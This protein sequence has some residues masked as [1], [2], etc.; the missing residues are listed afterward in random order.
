MQTPTVAETEVCIIGAG[1]AGLLVATEL[2]KQQIHVVILE[3][4]QRHP[5]AERPDYAK[6]FLRGENPWQSAVPGIDAH[7]TAGRVRYSLDWMRAR[8]VGGSSLHWEGY[9]LR[10]HP[11]DF[12][13]R[14]VHGIADD[15]PLTYEKLEP[16]YASA[17]R[18]LGVAGVAD[19]PWA[20][21]RSSAFP[22]P[23]FPF[24][25][26][27]ALFL[28]AC[29]RL[30]IAL[31]HL[32]QA[33]NSIAYAGR[34]QCRACGTCHVCPTGAKASVDLTHAPQLEASPT[35]QILAET[36]ALRLQVDPSG[37]VGSV[38]YVGP[39]RAQHEL[40]S[41]IFVL[42]AGGV[43]TPRLLLLS[44]SPS[45][46][47]GLANRSGCV[48]R[49]FMSHPSLDVSGR[50]DAKTYPYRIGFSTAMCRQFAVE[51]DRR[52]HGAFMLEILNRAGP[53]PQEI[54]VASGA[55]GRALRQAVAEQFG[56]WVGIRIYCEQL[57]D[58]QNAVTLDPTITDPFGQPV[59]HLTYDVGPYERQ[60]LRRALDIATSIL[61]AMG[62]AEI[63]VAHLWHGAHQIGT[64]RMG[65]DP[66]SS[67]VDADLRCHDVENLYLVG[68]G[69]FVT[70][71]ASPPTL[72]IAA[73]ATRA[74][75]HIASILRHRDQ[76]GSADAREDMCKSF[77]N[78]CDSG[79]PEAKF[80]EA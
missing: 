20:A 48:G 27:D 71:S 76:R 63:R 29:S 67:V 52:R 5:L 33:R 19:D 50:L 10:L 58:G 3:S 34:S 11:D 14:R 59:P 45:H 17:E 64:C 24:S 18:A 9:T 78:R 77:A 37:R 8:G 40:K 75:E 47:H 62:A 73:L 46:P 42:A 44:S 32:P 49:Y 16:Y 72:T 53:A 23:P 15:W 80:E 35:V 31:Q 60:T 39:D 30:G 69:V 1:P 61:R 41:R 26:S 36:T 54:A 56:H 65:V 43:E 4:G 70:G 74:G 25:Y 6:R 7:T 12:Q 66:A 68:S 22:L 2:A 21:P 13:L 28:Q 55:P 51:G 38:L 57:P 79:H